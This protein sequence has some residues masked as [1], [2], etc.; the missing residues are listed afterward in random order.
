MTTQNVVPVDS[1]NRDVDGAVRLITRGTSEYLKSHGITLVEGLPIVMSD[2]EVTAA[3]VCT[4]R[5]G[6]WVAIV[7]RWMP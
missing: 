3:G 2:G 7:N 6:I 1:G 5:E 4:L